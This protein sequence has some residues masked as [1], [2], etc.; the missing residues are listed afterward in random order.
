MIRLT[1]GRTSPLATG[2]G[3][4]RAQSAM[5]IGYARCVQTRAASDAQNRIWRRRGTAASIGS[6]PRRSRRRA[7]VRGEERLV[8]RGTYCCRQAVVRRAVVH[9]RAD[10]V[11]PPAGAERALERLQG[12]AVAEAAAEVQERDAAVAGDPHR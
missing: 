11:G 8:R 5:T 1:V 6:R 9:S 10:V 4:S 2:Q 7:A 12:V 3:R